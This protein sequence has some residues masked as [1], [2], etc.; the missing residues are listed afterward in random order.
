MFHLTAR[1]VEFLVET[2][3]KSLIYLEV[4][5]QGADEKI[6]ILGRGV[7]ASGTRCDCEVVVDVIVASDCERVDGVV[8]QLIGPLLPNHQ[9]YLLLCLL[10]VI[11]LLG[12]R[13]TPNLKPTIHS[14]RVVELELA[15]RFST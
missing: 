2:I 1:A 4:A 9:S 10:E 5:F 8:D 13:H 3:M 15:S 7:F 14:I 12:H 6:L 11:K